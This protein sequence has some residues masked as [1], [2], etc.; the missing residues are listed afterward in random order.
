MFPFASVLCLNLYSGNF[1]FII[2]ISNFGVHQEL[3][4]SSPVL[5]ANRWLM[6]AEI[7]NVQTWCSHE[8][9]WGGYAGNLS[10]E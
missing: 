1:M 7:I 5:A 2:K 10:D 8:S 6:L 9:T 3:L 4:F